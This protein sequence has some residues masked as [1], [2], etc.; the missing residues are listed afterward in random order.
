[1]DDLDKYINQRIKDD[2]KFAEGFNSGYTKF[3]LGYILAKT[4]NNKEFLRKNS[5]KN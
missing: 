3:K 4:M 2:P 5:L 1:M